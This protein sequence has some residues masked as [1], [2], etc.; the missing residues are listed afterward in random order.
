MDKILQDYYY[1]LE[2]SSSL[3]RAE[4]LMKYAKKYG[5]E[6]KEK[7]I[8]KWLRR[9][10]PHSLHFPIKTKFKRN[11]IVS[12]FINHIWFADLIEIVDYKNNDDFK[13][14]LAVIDNL[15]K[16]G[17]AEPLK[18]KQGETVK[19]ALLKIFRDSGTKPMI[20]VT[21]SG[22]EFTNRSLKR[23]LN[24]RKIKHLILKDT[25]K[26][27]VVE[28][29]NQTIKNKLYKY[30][31]AFNTMKFIDVLPKI[32][33]NYNNTIHSRT[34]YKPNEVTEENQREV[35][36]NLYRLKQTQEPGILSV[37]DEV[38]VI[39]TRSK[40]D[41]GFKPNYSDEI[42]RIYKIYRTSPYYKYR[43]KD[44]KNRL[45]RGS[46]YSKELMKVQ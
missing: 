33:S 30:L 5:H 1:N 31:T 24:W 34:K 46:Y 41:K 40:F 4:T 38:R 12:K 13:Y 45:V 11:P 25:T 39:L 44:D 37:G 8:D 7:D 20:L 36:R 23:Y 2:H 18:N 22:T 42:F 29:W 32:V 9:Q 19:K 43:I 14:I 26:A 17:F 15:S 28:R 16:K 35:F 10:R 6:L 3:G 27:S 21:D